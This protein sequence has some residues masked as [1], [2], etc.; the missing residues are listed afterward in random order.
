MIFRLAAHSSKEAGAG[1]RPLTRK[2]LVSVFFFRRG[3]EGFRAEVAAMA[4]AAGDRRAGAVDLG[5]GVD[6]DRL[7]H[8]VHQPRG[9]FFRLAVVG[10]VQLG[11]AVGSDAGGVGRVATAAARAQCVGPLIHQL[12]NLIAGHVFWQKFQIGGRGVVLARRW[13]L[14]VGRGLC[15]I[16]RRGG[17]WRL[18]CISL[19]GRLCERGG[20]KCNCSEHGAGREGKKQGVGFQACGVPLIWMGVAIKTH[21]CAAGLH[22]TR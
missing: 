11:L 1:S 3:Y 17:N 21:S 9:G 13:R 20:G 19:Q 15:S 8:G 10:V 16:D 14:R 2:A 7:C 18:G 4:G 6:V 22:P 12:I 5:N